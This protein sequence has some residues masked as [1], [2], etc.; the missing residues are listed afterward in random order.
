MLFK[1]ILKQYK[2]L[3]MLADLLYKKEAT[4]YVSAK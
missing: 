4:H 3:D 2:L 1:F